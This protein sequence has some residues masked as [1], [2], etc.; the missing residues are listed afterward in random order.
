VTP[1]TSMQKPYLQLL[2]AL[3]LAVFALVVAWIYGDPR[4]GLVVGGVVLVSYVLA[5]ALDLL[6]PR[7]RRK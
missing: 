5:A 2:W 3:G 7:R 6:P 4:W 1:P